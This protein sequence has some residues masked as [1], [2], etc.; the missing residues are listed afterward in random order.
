MA[1]MLTEFAGFFG[2]TFHQDGRCV[3]ANDRMAICPIH[4]S[5]IALGGDSFANLAVYNF[6]LRPDGK[7]DRIWTV[8]LDA[9]RC[10][11]FW[12]KSPGPPSKDFS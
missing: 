12:Q 7:T 8:D 1:L 4:E 6:R 5:G 3:Y 2:D 9:E 11:D 10:Q